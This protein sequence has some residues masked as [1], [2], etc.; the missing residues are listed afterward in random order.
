MSLTMTYNTY[1]FRFGIVCHLVKLTS[2]RRA[3]ARA[4]LE[5]VI[6]VFTNDVTI[7][8]ITSYNCILKIVIK[9]ANATLH[10]LSNH[11]ENS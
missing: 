5:E 9:D 4:A 1:D 7:I 11:S 3:I 10:R 6:S 8:T 2:G